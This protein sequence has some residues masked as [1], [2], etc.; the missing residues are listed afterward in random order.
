[1]CDHQKGRK[2]KKK[3]DFNL[4]W[5]PERICNMKT[6]NM[7]NVGLKLK[8]ARIISFVKLHQKQKFPK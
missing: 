4:T 6:I 1:M 3:P 7:D 2:K 5:A 8:Q